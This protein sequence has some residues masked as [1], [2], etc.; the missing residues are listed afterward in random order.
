MDFD[1]M[2]IEKKREDNKN[3]LRINLVKARLRNYREDLELQG[4]LLKRV[5]INRDRM[6]LQ[7]GWS[8]SEAVQGGGSSQEDRLNRLIDK[9]REDERSLKLIELENRALSFAIESLHDDDMRYIVVHK[10]L[11]DDMAMV[12]IGKKLNLSKSTVWRKS[13]D[14]LLE[15]YNKL[16]ILTTDEVD[17]R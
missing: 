16:Y 4:V 5:E 17:P 2:N 11:Y 14:A 6:D 9:I 8:S 10:W 3:R 12:D 13:D 1:R 15:I 7:S